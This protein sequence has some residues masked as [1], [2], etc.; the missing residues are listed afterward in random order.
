M[1]TKQNNLNRR[2]VRQK[3][4]GTHHEPFPPN[5]LLIRSTERFVLK[6]NLATVFRST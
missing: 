2:G 3:S 6:A 1:K 4:H 5:L